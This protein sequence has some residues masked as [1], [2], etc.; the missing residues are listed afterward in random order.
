[1]KIYLATLLAMSAFAAHAHMESTLSYKFK[2]D[3]AYSNFCKAVLTD[4]VDLLKRS[5]RSK[6]GDVATSRKEVLRKL[7][8]TDGMTCND[9]SLVE[10]SKQR[11]AKEVYAYLTE[12][13]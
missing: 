4:D 3:Q 6:V 5:I 13:L 10:F 11:E 12:A 1:M 7:I 8:S 2:G 9:I